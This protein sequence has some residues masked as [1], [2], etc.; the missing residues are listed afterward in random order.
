[1]ELAYIGPPAAAAAT[2]AMQS[3]ASTN[4]GK[5]PYIALVSVPTEPSQLSPPVKEPNTSCLPTTPVSA[6]SLTSATQAFDRVDFDA[7]HFDVGEW[8][9]FEGTVDFDGD[10]ISEVREVS[11]LSS[12][13]AEFLEANVCHKS[14]DRALLSPGLSTA[15]SHDMQIEKHTY[16][17]TLVIGADADPDSS[18]GGQGAD[19]GNGGDQDKTAVSFDSDLRSNHFQSTRIGAVEIVT[20]NDADAQSNG[21]AVQSM[22]L[23]MLNPETNTRDLANLNLHSAVESSLTEY[24]R[25]SQR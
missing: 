10:L 5:V 19:R 13:P 17:N 1:L 15:D 4:E 21:G 14:R 23:S 2:A 12:D 16:R 25:P 11:A 22:P 8:F 18:W 20:D 9:D 6:F 7:E 3:S 24:A